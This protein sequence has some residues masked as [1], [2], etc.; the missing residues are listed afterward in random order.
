VARVGGFLDANLPRRAD[1]CIAVT[2]ELG[3][4]LRRSGV[5]DATLAC[6]PPASAPHELPPVPVD[7]GASTSGLVCYA[8]NLDGYQN[9]GFLLESFRRV[10]AVEPQ[11]R[12]VL[13]THEGGR[14]EAQ[15]LAACGVD[16]GV[17]V[18][19]VRSYGEVRR[20]LD[21]SDVAVSPRT[22]RC[23]FPMKLLNYMAAGKAIV[24]AAG[25]AKGLRDGVTGRIVP[26]GDAQ[27][28]G[29]AIVELLRDSDARRRL[30]T[31]ARAA[32]EDP[33]AWEQVLD[34]IESI[35]RRVLG[36]NHPRLVP[37]AVAE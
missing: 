35:Y 11:A 28:F 30:G 25:S 33:A 23:G 34:R 10:R 12:L 29:D 22:E 31:A 36:R 8:G 27:A 3:D 16:A 5:T 17:E 9:L 7:A 20:L 19:A 32:V 13:V 24:A 2:D 1:F 14:A 15:R 37:V 4:V 26:D 21:A 18:V 6:I